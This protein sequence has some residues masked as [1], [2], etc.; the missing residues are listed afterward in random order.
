LTPALTLRMA[1]GIVSGV[2][3][4]HTAVES[5]LGKAALAH[6]DLKSKN[7]LVK[8]D[9]ACCVGDLGLALSGDRHGRVTLPPHAV[10]TGTKRYMAPEVLA[11]SLDFRLLLP[12]QRADM[13][14]LA[15]VLWELLSNTTF[16]LHHTGKSI[17]V[18]HFF[19]SLSRHILNYMFVSLFLGAVINIWQVFLIT[20]QF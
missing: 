20:G 18:T 1:L 14:S 10:R 12:F 19:L 11:R 16:T 17:T 6:C 7:V 15:L 3:H 13:Y 5:C 4:L 9:L 2:E 8:G